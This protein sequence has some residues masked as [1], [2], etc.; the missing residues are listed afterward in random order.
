VVVE[1]PLGAARGSIGR[2]DRHAGVL[3]CQP[4]EIGALSCGLR[5]FMCVLRGQTRGA[6]GALR[7]PPSLEQALSFPDHGF[8]PTVPRDRWLG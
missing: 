1:R 8:P 3:G 7:F 2:L 6:R 4:R 5:R